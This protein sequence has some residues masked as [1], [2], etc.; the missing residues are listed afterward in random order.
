MFGIEWGTGE[1]AFEKSRGGREEAQIQELRR[2]KKKS[3]QVKVAHTCNP[4][5][6]KDWRIASSRPA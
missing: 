2:R 3:E 5:H 6:S 1:A 4:S